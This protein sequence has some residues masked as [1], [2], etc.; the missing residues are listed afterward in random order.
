MPYLTPRCFSIVHI[1]MERREPVTIAQL[2]RALHVSERTI[3]YD[4][5][6]LEDWLAEKG[7]GLIRKS[8]VGIC[9]DPVSPGYGELDALFTGG[10][11]RQRI[12]S[13]GERQRLIRR[14]LLSGRPQTLAELAEL[15]NVSR[16]TAFRDLEETEDWLKARRLVLIRGR[17]ISCEGSELDARKA[18]ADMI[19]ESYGLP[20]L[21]K[22]VRTRQ[23]VAQLWVREGEEIAAPALAEAVAQLQ[24]ELGMSF[25]DESAAELFIHFGLTLVRAWQGKGVSLPEQN[26]EH[27]RATEEYTA[28]GRVLGGLAARLGMELGQAELCCATMHV[29]G[30]GITHLYRPGGDAR[31]GETYFRTAVADFIAEVSRALDRDL[32]HDREL[33]EDLMLELRPRVS[34]ARFQ[35]GIER[36]PSQEL[37]TAYA[38][39]F[40]AVWE[41]MPLL[42]VQFGVS[43]DEALAGELSAHIAA[44]Q[45]RMGQGQSDKYV[46]A[47]VVCGAGVGT[48][49]LLASRITREF[50]QIKV[51]QEL[52]MAEFQEF[53]ASSVDLI[54]SAIPMEEAPVNFIEVDPLLDR[55]SCGRISRY[56]SGNLNRFENRDRYIQKIMMIVENNC[57]IENRRRLHEELEQFLYLEK[58]HELFH[59]ARNHSMGA[60]VTKR[61]IAVGPRAAD[62]REAI[63]IGGELLLRGGS[64]EREYIDAMIEHTIAYPSDVVVAPGVAL[65]H[66]ASKGNVR[67]VCMSLTLLQEPVSFH[68][69]RNDPVKLVVCLG[70]VDNRSHEKAIYDFLKILE[71]KYLLDGILNARSVKEILLTINGIY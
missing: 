7:V 57:T 43:F 56:L 53:D 12:Y 64:I 68:H 6:T 69:P 14:Q 33:L 66:A 18:L 42:E 45:E 30:A 49:K 51:L 22:L 23:S 36:K 47:I 46:T 37:R 39:I 48:A 13:G 1:L 20:I 58:V 15:T 8:R 29:L 32:T 35:V 63:T 65:A 2:S 55:E 52:S 10:M 16:S 70:T 9:L 71:N 38:G 59:T 25:T 67:E 31:K 4:L 5:D 28:T 61:R 19:Y 3:R 34:R 21:L 17:C 60:L 11:D 50:G 40:R 26:M 44:A 54:F 27:L 24:R 62:F 41:A